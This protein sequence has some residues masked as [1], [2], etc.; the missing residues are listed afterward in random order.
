MAEPVLGD[1]DVL[2][3]VRIDANLVEVVRSFRTDVVVV[4]VHLR[5]AAAAVRGSVD[6]TADD[7]DDSGDPRAASAGDREGAGI[8]V[9]D[10]RVEDLGVLQVDVEADSPDASAGKPAP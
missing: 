3:V 2:V 9:L 7:V 1:E 6:L 10:D 5:P 8:V 4:R